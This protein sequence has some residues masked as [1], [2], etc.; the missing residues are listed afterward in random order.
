MTLRKLFLGGLALAVLAGPAL[1]DSRKDVL[2]IV[3]EQ[4]QNNLDLHPPGPNRP[5]YGHSWNT[6]DRLLSYG[7]KTTPTGQLSYDYQTLT[8]ELAEKWEYADGGKSVVFH[9]RKDARF[10]DGTPVTARDVKWSLDRAV[11]VGGFPSF[12]MKAGSIAKPDQFV[13]VDDHTFK[14]KLLRK[15]KLTLPDIAVPIPAIYNSK[16]VKKHATAKD[17]WALQWTKTNMAGGGAYKMISWK[18]GQ[19]TVY[20]RNDGWKSGPRPAIKR[21]VLR[22][23]PSAASR[24]ALLERGDVDISFDL[25]PKDF[26]ELEKSGKAKVVG[27]LIENFYWYLSMNTTKPPFN[28]VKIRKAMAYAIPYDAIFNAVFFKRGRPLYGASSEKVTSTAWPQPTYYKS[29]IAHAKSLMAEAGYPDGFKSTMSINIG[30]ATVSEPMALLIQES[31]SKIGIKIVIDKKPSSAFR[32]AMVKKTM[33]M[34]LNNFGGWLNYPD[35]FFRW[36]HHGSGPLFNTSDYKNPK[37]D[38]LIEAA[39]AASDKSKYD[40][41]VKKM[42]QLSFDEAPNIPI[43]QAYLDVAMKKN[44][45]GYQYWFHRQLDFRQLVKK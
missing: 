41:L 45:K 25:P 29:D 4:G 33:P 18:P 3:R 43:L 19:Q 23:V 8:P 20:Q 40:G 11:S 1:A 22:E 28:N 35:Y 17:P 44:I 7:R 30:T 31:L 16:L 9:L 42:I 34:N 15:D 24:R 21:I 13:V 36:T 12:Q 26:A 14:L 2:V 37:M 27:V 6:Y 5:S 32:A 10:H 38:A 39:G